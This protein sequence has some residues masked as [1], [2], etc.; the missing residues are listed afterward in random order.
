ML[1]AM[2]DTPSALTAVAE[3]HMAPTPKNYPPSLL[4]RGYEQG[5]CDSADPGQA[6]VAREDGAHLQY[7]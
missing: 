2:D 3:L 1:C 4:Y 7:C 6:L 5:I